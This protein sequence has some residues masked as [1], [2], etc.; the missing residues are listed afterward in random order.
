MVQKMFIKKENLNLT[1]KEVFNGNYAGV[2]ED[3]FTETKSLCLSDIED[4]DIDTTFTNGS[5]FIHY[6]YNEDE[7]LYVLDFGGDEAP[8]C[9]DLDENMSL[10]EVIELT[11]KELIKYQLEY[12]D[13]F[14][15]LV[16]GQKNEYDEDEWNEGISIMISDCGNEYF[17]INELMDDKLP[18]ILENKIQENLEKLNIDN[19]S[20]EDGYL[21]IKFIIN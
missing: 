21:N 2:E 18:Q 7:D 15:E 19:I 20:F 4:V 1:I 11:K 9:I 16:E 17:Y 5:P 13:S 14:F 3:E 12:I 10:N 6:I 8:K